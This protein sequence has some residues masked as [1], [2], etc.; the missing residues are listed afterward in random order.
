MVIQI[1]LRGQNKISYNFTTFFKAKVRSEDMVKRDG[2][3][4]ITAEMAACSSTMVVLEAVRPW[5]QQESQRGT[6]YK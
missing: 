2:I 4:S 6:G 1:V 3:F 5:G